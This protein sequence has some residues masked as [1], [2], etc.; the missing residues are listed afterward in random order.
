MKN[1]CRHRLLLLK[2]T[3]TICRWTFN[4]G[5][6]PPDVIETSTASTSVLRLLSLGRDS[7]GIYTCMATRRDL[8]VVAD[9]SAHV[10]VRGRS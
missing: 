10:Q 9:A 3:Y 1:K 2:G 6:L 4:F 7:E 8:A 5:P